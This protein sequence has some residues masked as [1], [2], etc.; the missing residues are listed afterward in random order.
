[1]LDQILAITLK[2]LKILFKDRG[3]VAALFLMPMMFILVMSTALRGAFGSGSSSS[4]VALPVVNLDTG[5]LAAE[6]IADLK[7]VDGLSI[8]DSWNGQ[9]LTREVADQLVRDGE[10]RVAIVFPADF[11][12]QIL[13]HAADPRAAAALVT[14]IADPAVGAQFLGPIQG[15]VQ[16]FILRVA[17]YAQAPRQIQAAFGQMA[18][19]ADPR[20]APAITQ[21]GELFVEQL[22]ANGGL[23]GS[24][25]QSPVAFEQV[26]PA[27]F[28][29][30][31]FPDAAQQNVPGYTLFGVFFI[32]QV[33]AVSLLREKQ[34]G[35]FR[36]LLAAPL[37]RAALLIGK[38]LPYYLVNLIQV[39]LMFAVGVVALRMTLGNDMP[40]L[41]LI[42]LAA[43]L[44]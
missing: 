3:G 21:I 42:T 20:L 41:V 34:D 24:A 30:Q 33:L 25:S 19:E 37:P 2:D 17:S 6:A 40:A 39:A 16:G 32:A 22:S 44:A 15:T 35:T 1:M 14:F 31:K 28:K 43:S 10:R 8:E 11:T 5:T 12:E 9:P 7:T 36:R 26:A 29:A 18:A 13:K 4:P 27:G 38:L 23:R